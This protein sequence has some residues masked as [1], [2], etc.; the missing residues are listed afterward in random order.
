M[1]TEELHIADYAEMR[2]RLIAWAKSSS[3]S[4]SGDVEKSAQAIVEVVCGTAK[5]RQSPPNG[6]T[7]IPSTWPNL[8]ML[9]LGTD[10]D[11]NIRDKCNAILK[12][13][14]EWRDVVRGIS[15]EN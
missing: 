9:V 15:L 14:D 11:E 8:N 10:A 6:D 7:S 5:N 4:I 12:N 3:S 2:K 1:G 13:L